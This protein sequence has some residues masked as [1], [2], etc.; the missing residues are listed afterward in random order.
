VNI[1]KG[2]QLIHSKSGASL[3]ASATEYTPT[4]N[5]Q[6]LRI[7]DHVFGNFN[8]AYMGNVNSLNSLAS[9]GY[10]LNSNSDTGTVKIYSD[11]GT[12]DFDFTADITITIKV[13][14]YT[15]AATIYFRPQYSN[16]RKI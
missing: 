11:G 9:Y 6:F 1:Y 13:K 7:G 2:A 4:H 8:L 10:T 16:T 15:A 3:S 12:Y 5:I 14:F